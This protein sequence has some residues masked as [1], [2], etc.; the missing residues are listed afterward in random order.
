MN[1]S[2]VFG[3]IFT[4]IVIALLLVFG[5]SQIQSLICLSNDGAIIKTIQDMDT[6]VQGLYGEAEGSSRRVTL[7]IPSSSQICFLNPED[8]SLNAVG[9]D[10]QLEPLIK[11]KGYNVWTFQC[12]GQYGYNITHL[13]AEPSFCAKSGELYLENKGDYVSIGKA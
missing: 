6:R 11:S 1:V 5:S 13:V 10:F 2:M 8:L 7:R 9:I 3:I 4:I 12:S